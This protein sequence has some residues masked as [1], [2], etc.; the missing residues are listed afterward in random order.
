MKPFLVGATFAAMAA[1]AGPAG[2]M[3]QPE[4]WVGA[5]SLA[6]Y[7][8]SLPSTL[9]GN[10]GDVW[11]PGPPPQRIVTR[12]ELGV[13]TAVPSNPQGGVVDAIS[14]GDDFCG[15]GVVLFFYSVTAGSVGAGYPITP[16]V[17]TNGAAGDVF[18]LA[19]KGG[20]STLRGPI[21]ETD[22]T[23]IVLLPTP[24]Q[25]ELS[26]LDVPLAHQ[27][28]KRPLYFSVDAATAGRMSILSGVP[29]EPGDILRS[30]RRGDWR[31]WI[32]HTDLGLPPGTDLDAL[33]YDDASNQVWFSVSD[34]TAPA[35]LDGATVYIVAPPVTPGTTPPVFLDPE[36][37]GCL[38][39]DDV[40]AITIL[41][42]TQFFGISNSP[43]LGLQFDAGLLDGCVETDPAGNLQDTLWHPEPMCSSPYMASPP[44]P[45]FFPTISG[46]PSAV[47]V[48]GS[49][50]DDSMS[51]QQSLG[52]SFPYF[53]LP[54]STFQVSAN[55]FL[56]FNQFL[57][58]GFW[59][60]DPIP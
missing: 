15:L 33:A 58:G 35:G 18:T 44:I 60:N 17:A 34:S 28:W 19:A 13:P 36:D 11:T 1:L 14:M 21:L 3:R 50:V 52:F 30:N 32:S 37:L 53:G 59:E 39:S 23:K 5:F 42:P 43:F 9:L 56:V 48:L 47:T 41:D 27:P 55:G 4:G 49:G 38:P 26:T 24:G 40:D 46:N 10:P 29:V 2:A 16:E 25:D 8:P 12:A 54:K 51:P 7:S 31:I 6:Q 22:A 20:C 57:G 45:S